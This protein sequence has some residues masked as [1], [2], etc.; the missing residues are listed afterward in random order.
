MRQ[1]LVLTFI[2]WLV[3]GLGLSL[4][5]H[6]TSY[7]E[8]VA[9][10]A[11]PNYAAEY[12]GRLPV[13]T[14]AR[15]EALQLGLQ[16][17]AGVGA[18]GLLVLRLKR[19]VGR[20][21][22]RRPQNKIGQSWQEL[23]TPQRVLVAGLGLAALGV[24][25]WLLVQ[26]P[27]TTDEL[28]SFDYYVRLGGAVTASNY[29]LPNNHILYN[30]LV[31][32]LPTGALPPDWQQRLPAVLIGVMLLPISYLLLLRYL[33]FGAATLALGLFTFTPMAAFYSI[34]GRGYGLQLAAVV[35]G[36]FATL[37]LLAG[38]R[39][40][41]PW[42]VFVVSGVVGLYAVPT[43]LYALVAL[44]LALLVG[45]GRQAGRQRQLN[46]GQLGLA[47]FAIGTTTAVLYAPVGAVLGWPALLHNPYVQSLS[48]AAFGRGLYDPYLLGMASQLW[49]QGRASLLGLAVLAGV[50]ALALSRWRGPARHL[51]WLSYALVF[52]PLLLLAAQRV[53]VPA[54]ALLPSVLF[55]FVLLA[56]LGQEMLGPLAARLRARWPRYWQAG[57]LG[58]L[59]VT[60]SGYGI[61]RLS[62]EAV[63]MRAIATQHAHLRQQL[64]WLRAQGPARV[65]L[66]SLSRPYQGIYWYH[67]GVVQQVPMP[68]VVAK[69]L[70]TH[71]TQAGANEYAVFCRGRG[72]VPPPAL[73]AQAPAYTDAYIY[74]WKLP[75]LPP[76]P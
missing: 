3:A 72:T 43:H 48:W 34:A 40:R 20:R 9:A 13:L 65:W 17:V 76:A 61:Y 64:G 59:L 66:D 67:L 7:N 10:L 45:F 16:L 50:G 38:G 70:P 33:R 73:A 29:S 21:A 19:G 22:R 31:G 68:L 26:Q 1:L 39:R 28:T 49:G 2:L 62:H 6:A 54:R 30:L 8:L 52:L 11:Q 14:P 24:R 60:I 32:S 44:G 41:E 42:V 35:A 37:A 58:L 27:I 74:V 53:Y 36:F 75:A 69:T 23:A 18:A 71:A 46:I 4:L 56:L 63:G 55:S 51:G 25:A 57:T 47:T 15:Y 5:L 12:E